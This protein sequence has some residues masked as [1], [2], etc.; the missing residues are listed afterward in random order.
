MNSIMR[1]LLAIPFVLILA[2]CEEDESGFTFSRQA[3]LVNN[4]GTIE[5][6]E[7]DFPDFLEHHKLVTGSG[8][9]C[10]IGTPGGFNTKFLRCW[11]RFMNAT[12]REQV[13]SNLG[14]TQH[15]L[16]IGEDHVCATLTDYGG[17]R[18]HCDGSNDFGEN[19]DPKPAQSGDGYSG[20]WVD[21]PYVVASGNRHNCT[22]DRYGL[23]C[24]GDNRQGQTDS[25]SISQPKWVAAGG[26]TS[27][28]IDGEDR[29]HCWGD[30]AL[31]QTDVPAN[32]GKVKY[33]DVGSEFVCAVGLE[34]DNITCW[35][36]TNWLDNPSLAPAQSYTQIVHVSVGAQHGC[37]VDE[38]L[39]GDKSSRQIDCFGKPDDTSLLTLPNLENGEQALDEVE[40]FTVSA[41]DGYSCLSA[42]YAGWVLDEESQDWQPQTQQGITCWGKNQEGAAKVPTKLCLGY[43]S[44]QVEEDARTCPT[45]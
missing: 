35:G 39:A 29:L 34:Q 15:M 42:S 32:L 1:I 23:Y 13:N 8:R 45:Y 37:V 36:D 16:S 44:D 12:Q 33:V 18:I 14:G 25:P 41:G 28:A 27:C 24:W 31:G 17:R 7:N 3:E 10:A 19:T 4:N 9:T 20:H 6:L 26:D 30:N 38:T 11:G 21:S 40:L 5:Q 22:V 2:A 43:Y